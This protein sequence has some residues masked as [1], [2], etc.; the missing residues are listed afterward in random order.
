[1]GR[2]ALALLAAAATGAAAWRRQRRKR[3]EHVDLYFDDGSMVSL[4][5]D[6]EEARRLLPLAYEILAT[7]RG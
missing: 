7:A 1:M 2:R 3:R 5:D 6:T 4:A